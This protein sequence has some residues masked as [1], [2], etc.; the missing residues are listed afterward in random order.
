MR[1]NFRNGLFWLTLFLLLALLPLGIASAG[2]VPEYRTF[3]IEFGVALGFIGLSMFGLLFLFS[4]RFERV[5]PI[6]GMDN[7]IN[8]HRQIGIVAFF[9]VLAHRSEEHTS[10]LQSR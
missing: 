1:Y 7:I 4:G 6:F 3:W 9:L 10:E 2:N 8:F 5:A